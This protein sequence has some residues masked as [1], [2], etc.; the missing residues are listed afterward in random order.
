MVITNVSYMC[1]V[2]CI[3]YD[4]IGILRSEGRKEK[5]YREMKIWMQLLKLLNFMT[6]K[7]LCILKLFYFGFSLMC[8]HPP[9]CGQVLAVLPCILP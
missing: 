5:G 8:I 4:V 2:Q 6:S 3:M 9:D 7:V 1:D